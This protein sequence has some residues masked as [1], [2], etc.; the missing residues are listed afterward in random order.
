MIATLGESLPSLESLAGKVGLCGAGVGLLWAGFEL[1]NQRQPAL[2]PLELGYCFTVW[3]VAMALFGI[4][5]AARGTPRY[6][7][8]VLTG[9]LLAD[10]AFT[11]TCWWCFALH[12]V[13]FALVYAGTR[14][15]LRPAAL[16]LLF[17]AMALTPFTAHSVQ[18][19]AWSVLWGGIIVAWRRPAWRTVLL[20]L[21]LADLLWGLVL[22]QR[23]PV[24]SAG[25]ASGEAS[26]TDLEQ[27]SPSSR[28]LTAQ[29]L[30]HRDEYYIRVGNEYRRQRNYELAR[31][32]YSRA[33]V[34]NGAN[35]EAHFGLA[36]TAFW[37]GQP[38]EAIHAFETSIL[39]GYG[40]PALAYRGIGWS[41]YTLEEYA[42]A[43]E[44]FRQAAELDPG[45]ADAYNG[46]GWVALQEQDC[47]D[48][49]PYFERALTLDPDAPEPQN[50]L[51]ICA[52]A[53]QDE[54]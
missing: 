12:V 21:L 17:L 9:L 1:W 29:G 47:E 40:Q 36:E 7:P 19:V 33:L 51:S 42:R 18:D 14:Q 45:L 4:A 32:A 53:S 6:G 52:P 34:Y 25:A 41:W 8:L 27:A 3:A 50:G 15:V 37:L 13:L 35:A 54:P 16:L 10:V 46:L 31:Q 23:E 39:C 43:D 20:G 24:G 49:I 28:Q 26:A 30:A 38:E 22:I 2:R 44:A 48:A 5:L 11:Y